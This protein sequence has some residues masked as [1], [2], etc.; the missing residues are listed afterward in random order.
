MSKSNTITKIE[1]IVENK[2]PANKMLSQSRLHMAAIQTL[3]TLI[4]IELTPKEAAWG[5]SRVFK[6]EDPIACLD[7]IHLKPINRMQ[8]TNC[9]GLG[10]HNIKRQ[11]SVILPAGLKSGQEISYPELGRCDL[12]SGKNSDLIIKIKIGSRSTLEID[13][14]T[15]TCTLQISLHEALLGAEIE[16][17]IVDNKVTIKIN[18]LT[19]PGKVYLLKGKGINGGDLVINIKIWMPEILTEEESKLLGKI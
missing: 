10:Y 12:R 5:T 1:S 14:K 8:C 19:R 2:L 17:P 7:C 13:G 6:I 3:P 18:P 11:V 9:K 16:I 15:V 4:Q